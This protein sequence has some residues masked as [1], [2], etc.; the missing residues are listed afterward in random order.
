MFNRVE[1][2]VQDPFA[3]RIAQLCGCNLNTGPWIAGGVARLLWFGEDYTDHDID[4][5][6]PDSNSAYNAYKELEKDCGCSAYNT[7]N[8]CTFTLDRDG[9]EQKVQ[10]INRNRYQSLDKLFCYFDFTVCR[11][12]TDGRTLVSDTKTIEHCEK[13]Q[14]QFNIT[15]Q[16]EISPF[17]VMKYSAYGFETDNYIFKKLVA[18]YL[19]NPHEFHKDPEYNV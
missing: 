16:Q 14:L 1:K 9:K 15:S 5:F 17:R 4:V 2:P 7:Q 6:F 11:F 12:A 8:A 13:K 18:K 19:E 3:A 10:L